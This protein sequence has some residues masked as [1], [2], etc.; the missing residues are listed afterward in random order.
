M[1]WR[2]ATAVGRQNQ[3]YFKVKLSLSIWCKNSYRSCG[4]GLAQLFGKPV[5]LGMEWA[6]RQ[7]GMGVCGIWEVCLSPP[8]GK[9]ATT[10]PLSSALA[11]LPTHSQHR[12][13]AGRKL[14]A[15]C[16]SRTTPKGVNRA[17]QLS[18]LSFHPVP[19]SL[20]L[21]HLPPPQPH[22]HL[23]QHSRAGSHAI[24]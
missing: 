7:S 5:S 6:E 22:H 3:D 17:Q 4:Q 15:L 11:F 24:F 16:R 21:I 1:S 23:V 19:P 12:V 9:L 20:P 8:P 14:H 18:T 13:H 2:L 10:L